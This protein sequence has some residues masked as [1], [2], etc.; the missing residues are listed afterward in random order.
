[1]L[2]LSHDE[3]IAAINKHV[4]QT[5]SQRARQ[6]SAE[7]RLVLLRWVREFLLAH[8]SELLERMPPDRRGWFEKRMRESTPQ[9]Q[10]GMLMMIGVGWDRG[11]EQRDPL[12]PPREDDLQKLRGGLSPI[13]R[14]RLQQAGSR[15][16]QLALLKGWLDLA[17][18]DYMQARFKSSRRLPTVSEQ[19][20]EEFFATGLTSE[21]RS[22]LLSLPTQEEMQRELRNLYF[23]G[24]PSDEPRDRPGPP[25]VRPGDRPT[26]RPP[27][28]HDGHGPPRGPHRGGLGRGGPVP[29][30]PPP[31]P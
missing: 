20:L 15:D 28:E 21:E 29:E 1:M 17:V 3:R 26:G 14:E 11:G 10:V 12:P 19:E 30:G 18:R 9:Q 23:R 27:R 13:A 22:R 8:R 7:D 4:S 25:E 16:G 24:S 5:V 6:L 31:G 2:A